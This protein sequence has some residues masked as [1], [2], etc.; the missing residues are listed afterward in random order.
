MATQDSTGDG[1]AHHFS[2]ANIPFGIASSPRFPSPQPVTRVDN[3]VIFLHK[4]YEQ[5]LLSSVPDLPDGVFKYSTLNALAA[6]PKTV[7]SAVREAIQKAW[8]EGSVSSES[9]EDVS[10]VTMHLPVHVS[11]FTDFSCSLEHVKNAGRIVINNDNPPPGFFHFPT[12]YAGRASSVVVSG[13]PIERPLG[14][15]PDRTA[16]VEP[17]AKPPVIF[18]PTRAL[19]YEVEFAAIIGTPLPMGQRTASVAAVDRHI[20]GF[21]LLNDWSARDIQGLEMLPLGPCNGKNLGTSVS[22]WVVVPDALSPFRAQGPEHVG[23]VAPHLADPVR[24]TFDVA[25]EVAVQPAGAGDFATVGRS[26]LKD[27]YWTPRQMVSHIVSAGAPLRTGDLMATG[28]VSGA[29]R[30]KAG[31][32]LEATE[33]GRVPL[34]LGA[35][36]KRAYLEDGDVVRITAV[37]G[38][39]DQGCPLVPDLPDLPQR[40]AYLLPGWPGLQIRQIGLQGLGVLDGLRST[41]PLRRQHGVRGVPDENRA[42]LAP[43]LERVNVAQLPQANVLVRRQ[44]DHGQEPVRKVLERLEQRLLGPVTVPSL[45]G[46]GLEQLIVGDE[47]D[48]TVQLPAPRRTEQHPP[49]VAQH[50]GRAGPL[51]VANLRRRAVIPDHGLDDGPRQ[52][53]AVRRQ[54]RRVD[55][56]LPAHHDVPQRRPDAVRAH[57]DVR[58]HH[59]AV[60]ERHGALFKI[61]AHDPARRPDERGRAGPVGALGGAAQRAVQVLPVVHDAVGAELGPVKGHGVDQLAGGVADHEGP[62]RERFAGLQER[63]QAP[64][65]DYS[66]GVGLQGDGRPDFAEHAGALEDGDLAAWSAEGDGLFWEVV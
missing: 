43:R 20:F 17:P 31:C 9:K 49:L 22:A 29:G 34:E 41:L 12:A 35:G 46:K 19:D 21:V 54:A 23:P 66:R 27:L 63:R 42:A 8:R 14:H 38:V 37:A 36:V 55:V 51:E 6:L 57:H 56:A 45:A 39:L 28:T 30:D 5:G 59:F 53:D 7:H 24:G 11:D 62:V 1:W 48:A 16:Q 52:V 33:G 26:S 2:V 25:F 15:F 3:D 32:L 50:H 58:V 65:V 61:A 60:L 44:L 18:A 13:T 64:V 47:A 40:L 4:L 10:G